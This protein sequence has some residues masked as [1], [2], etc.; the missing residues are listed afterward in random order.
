[1]EIVSGWPLAV[2]KIKKDGFAVIKLFGEQEID[3]IE[4]VSKDYLDK[5]NKI[6][7]VDSFL[8]IGRLDSAELRKC[9]T[10]IISRYVYPRIRA[11][12][13]DDTYDFISGIHLLKPPGKK[14]VLNPHQDSSLTD[15]SRFDSFYFWM[16]VTDTGQQDGTL[17]VIPGSH[18]LDIPFRSLN[19][20]WVLSA[21]ERKLW[22]YTKKIIVPRGCAV[23]FHSR[24]IHASAENTGKSVR[25]A[26]NSFL[27]PHGAPLLHYYTDKM[28]NNSIIEAYVITPDFFYSE[29]I[30]KKPSDAYPVYAVYSNTN[31]YYTKKELDFLFLK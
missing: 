28:S 24:L 14:G 12:I 16:P 17:E 5:I 6:D 26:V 9:S 15:E 8:A 20:P 25:I 7:K 11:F 27:K 19:I 29:D 2:D 30:L 4:R 31:R 3:E 13:G 1:M 21:H 10:A 23:L 18:L 22:N